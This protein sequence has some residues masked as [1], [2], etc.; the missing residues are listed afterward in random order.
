MYT[1][2]H[3]AR[4]FPVCKSIYDV[5]V[6]FLLALSDSSDSSRLCCVCFFLVVATSPACIRHIVN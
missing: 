5:M 4:T 6:Y 3:V 1:V 2:D